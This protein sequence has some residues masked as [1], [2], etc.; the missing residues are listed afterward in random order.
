MGRKDSYSYYSE[1]GQAASGETPGEERP[2][3]R[4]EN[5]SR[6]VECKKMKASTVKRK[7]D[8]AGRVLCDECADDLQSEIE[9]NK[10]KSVIDRIRSA[11]EEGS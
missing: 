9:K 10:T 6:C 4:E 3:I 2:D 7:G 8:L 11:K 1:A 5:K